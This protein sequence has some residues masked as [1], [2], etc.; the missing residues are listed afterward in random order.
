M[1]QVLLMDLVRLTDNP[2][3]V[4]RQRDAARNALAEVLRATYDDELPDHI[5]DKLRSIVMK[6]THAD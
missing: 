2:Q 5:A 6:G 1:R 3:R 4:L